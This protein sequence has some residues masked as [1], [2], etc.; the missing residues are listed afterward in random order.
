MYMWKIR[1]NEKQNCKSVNLK[2]P[3]V[4]K[5]NIDNQ[6]TFGC[7]EFIFYPIIGLFWSKTPFSFLIKL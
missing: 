4:E 7:L 6:I 2:V 3:K 1:K 5:R